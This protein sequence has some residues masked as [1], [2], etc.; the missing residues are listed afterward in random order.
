MLV[1]RSAW[2][3]TFCSSACFGS[4]SG[5]HAQQHLRVRRNAS[6]RRVHFV[7]HAGR[8]QTD[9]RKFLALLQL[10]FESDARGYVFEHNQRAGLF[11]RIL[12]RSDRD[13]QH[14]RAAGAVAV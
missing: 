10:L 3:R 1:A 5:K 9:R 14:Q 7:G 11:L 6:Q 4:V 2:R 13:V 12:Q 8:Q